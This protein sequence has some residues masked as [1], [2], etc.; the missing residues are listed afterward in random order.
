MKTKWCLFRVVLAS[1]A[2]TVCLEGFSFA[3]EA[4]ESSRA[5]QEQAVE[6]ARI[7]SRV[8]WT[9]VADGM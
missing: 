1:L 3:Q 7:M 2:I 6:Y 5:W 4:K 9:P 8:K